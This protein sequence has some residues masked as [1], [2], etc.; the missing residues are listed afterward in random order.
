MANNKM[1]VPIPKNAEE[2]IKLGSS[3]FNKHLV[4]KALSPLNSMADY[5]WETEGPKLPKALAKHLEAEELR[6]KMEAAYKERDLILANTAGIIRAS[7]DILVGVNRQNMKRLGD[8]GF[9]VESTVA[10]TKKKTETVK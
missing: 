1:R 2:L 8:W 10:A 6:K 4:E 5:K 7:R 3:I 9:T